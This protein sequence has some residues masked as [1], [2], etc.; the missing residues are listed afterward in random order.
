M[1]GLIFIFLIACVST[2]PTVVP[3]VTIV[4]TS[5]PSWTPTVTPVI[6]DLRV[7]DKLVNCRFGPGTVYELISELNEGQS[8]RAIGRDE[9]S[10]WWYVRDPG[11]PDGLCWV[12]R[13]VTEV[14]GVEEELPVISA[15]VSFVTKAKLRAEPDRISV[16]CDKFPQTI[17]LEAEITTNGPTFVTWRW[18]ASTG[19]S[20]ENAILVFEESGTKIINDYYQVGMPDDY[21]I[22][23]HIL[24]PNEIIEQVTVP[25]SCTP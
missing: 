24:Q 21:R 2:P 4:R 8:V 15:P 23:L 18:E 9:S 16:N 5:T 20:S 19:V 22:K 6:V 17:F 11:N 7:K 25:A 1:T 12:S 14:Q 3:T 13:N 10:A